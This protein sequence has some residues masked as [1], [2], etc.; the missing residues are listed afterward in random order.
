[1]LKIKKAVSKLRKEVLE[2]NVEVAILIN[3]MDREII[4]QMRQVLDDDLDNF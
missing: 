1:M 4:G 2:M 3:G